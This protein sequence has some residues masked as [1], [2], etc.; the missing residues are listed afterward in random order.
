MYIINLV[1][2]KLVSS[3]NKQNSTLEPG[4]VTGQEGAVKPLVFQI[5]GTFKFAI[6]VFR[7]CKMF[8]FKKERQDR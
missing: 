3:A 4:L 5:L 1:R 2:Q 6:T 8:A 7:K